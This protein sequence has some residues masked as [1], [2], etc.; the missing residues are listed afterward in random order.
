MPEL[1]E[2]ETVVRGLKESIIG[3][4][5]ES[6][7][8]S[9]KSFRYPYPA[10]FE[11]QIQGASITD[12]KRRAKYIL[13][14][15]NNSKTILIHLGMSG[16]ILVGH[17]LPQAKHDHADLEFVSK[18]QLKFNDAR[19]FGLITILET[20]NVKN[21]PLI[22]SQGFE[23]LEESF[24]HEYFF[25]LLQRRKTPIKL[26]LMDNVAVVGVGNIYASELLFRSKIHPSTPSNA[27]TVGQS[28]LIVS[29]IK[30]V[31]LEAIESGGSTLR[32]FVRSSGDMGYFQHK[33]HVYGKAGKPCAVC[34]VP[35]EKIV[36]GG[37]SAFYCPN[38]QKI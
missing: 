7:V 35:I 37:R 3:Q 33:F 25:P 30:T 15:L 24:N 23:P 12:V 18:I 29:S 8:M 4:I 34:S 19:R 11:E 31:L 38:C 9:G 2:V 17:N 5:I 1:P 36:I 6:L 16:K 14:E 21:Y 20:I 22:K 10:D 28:R 26:M 27:I 32:D 13:I